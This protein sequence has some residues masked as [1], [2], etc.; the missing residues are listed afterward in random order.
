MSSIVTRKHIKRAQ[1]GMFARKLGSRQSCVM[2]IQQGKGST[3]PTLKPKQGKEPRTLS[4]SSIKPDSLVTTR[5]QSSPAVNR[6]SVLLMV[7]LILTIK[8]KSRQ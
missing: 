4:G 3:R 1:H 6:N 7:A 5:P 8:A 2:R